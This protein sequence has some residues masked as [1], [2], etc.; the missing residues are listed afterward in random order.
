[1][2]AAL[3]SNFLLISKNK[4][5]VTL[6][7]LTLY[8]FSALGVVFYLIT[9]HLISELGH[10]ATHRGSEFYELQKHALGHIVGTA[11]FALIWHAYFRKSKRI[12]LTYFE[13]GAVGI[14]DRQTTL[15][16]DQTADGSATQAPAAPQTKQPEITSKPPTQATNTSDTVQ[17]NAE[18]LPYYEIA[19]KEA[20]NAAERVPG[21]WA[22]AFANADG[23]EQ[24]AKAEYI[25][26]R[27]PLII[28]EK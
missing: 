21:V 4:A 20:E 9:Q 8:A 22:M 10:V 1:M 17:S 23:D 25:R 16:R 28:E 7:I 2:A 3:I 13:T 24:R 12:Q 15:A 18:L 19:L 26:L 6:A 5:G 11:I 27:V 14:D